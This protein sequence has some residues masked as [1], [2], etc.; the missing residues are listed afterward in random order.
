MKKIIAIITAVAV[1]LAAASACVLR[2][3]KRRKRT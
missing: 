1:A 3:G 2:K